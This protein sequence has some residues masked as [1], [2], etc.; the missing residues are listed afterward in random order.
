M[1]NL[2]YPLILLLSMGAHAAAVTVGEPLKQLT[3]DSHGE[4]LLK[5][6]DIH[7]RPWQVDDMKGRVV[8]VQYMAARMGVKDLYK[9]LNDAIE[10]ADPG[11]EKF[12]VTAIVNLDDALW[13]TSG[14]ANS[15]M[16]DNKRR[17]P[18]SVIVADK[19]GAG[20]K[21]WQLQE[22]TGALILVD[23]NGTVQYFK[24]GGLTEQETAQ[25]VEQILAN[26]ARLDTSVS[27]SH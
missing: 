3:I 10:A 11:K 17:Y 8:L 24:Q 20:R 16:K 14:L 25:L 18:T 26:V 27:A 5:G 1:K 2:L 4:L 21:A 15:E 12:T 13:G 9:P 6:E 19:K 23:E 7:Y 22:K